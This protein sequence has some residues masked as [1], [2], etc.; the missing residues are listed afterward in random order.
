MTFSYIYSH[1]LILGYC[2]LCSFNEDQ[3]LSG[4]L[5]HVLHDVL[6]EDRLH[7]LI[8]EVGN[9]KEEA[10]GRSVCESYLYESKA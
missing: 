4:S 1:L 5:C 2:F 7:V 6:S 3:A 10:H 9:K 8:Y